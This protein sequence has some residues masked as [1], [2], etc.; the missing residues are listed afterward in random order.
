MEEDVCDYCGNKLE[1]S[2]VIE[3]AVRDFNKPGD[4]IESFDL[5]RFCCSLC[6]IQFIHV[7]ESFIVN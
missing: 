6:Q 4:S 2:P 7:Y 1:N 3:F 5:F